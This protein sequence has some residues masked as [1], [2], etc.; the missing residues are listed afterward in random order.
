L[1]VSAGIWWL[2]ALAIGNAERELTN[3]SIV[4]TELVDNAI[5]S[6][7]FALR[8]AQ[9]QVHVT[10][11]ASPDSR[12]R[13]HRL[14][15]DVV[16]NSPQIRTISVIDAD[17]TLRVISR[18]FPAIEHNVADRDYFREL[19]QRSTFGQSYLGFPVNSETTGERTLSISQAIRDDS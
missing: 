19:R 5:Q 3:L 14:F 13:L 15:K 16:R 7:D 10:G 17:G 1:L 12:F 6:A 8:D 2:H 18:E 4:V 9:A 11:L